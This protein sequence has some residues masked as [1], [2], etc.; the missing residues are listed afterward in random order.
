MRIVTYD[1]VDPDE[2]MF[3]DLICFGYTMSPDH[4]KQYRKLDKRIPN[5]YGLYLLDDEGRPISQVL[6]LHVDT[7]TEIGLEK[8][9]VIVGVATMPA[10]SRRGLST[11]LMK[12][13]HELAAERGMRTAILTTSASSVAHGLYTKLGYSTIGSFDL[14]IRQLTRKA[15]AGKGVKLRKFRLSDALALD[16]LFRSQNKDAL[17]FVYRQPRFFAMK[18][19]SHQISADGITVATAGD[20]IVGYARTSRSGGLVDVRELVADDDHTRQAILDAIGTESK[21]RWLTVSW[22]CDRK[23][24]HFY[25][26]LGFRIYSPCR[27]RVMTV[28]TDGLLSG[29]DITKLYGVN[30][31]RFVIN[32]DTVHIY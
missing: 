22:L 10:H 31:G 6:C 28:S 13:A 1:E 30:E 16:E 32:F 5:Y 17:G 21:A 23:M 14:G 7:R 18:V 3:L 26:R 25:T 20:E 9:A 27:P 15:R 11:T 8:V 4:L 19:Q 2:A 12:R 24:A 29:D